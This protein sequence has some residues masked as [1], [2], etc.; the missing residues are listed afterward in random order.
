MKIRTI[1]LLSSLVAIASCDCRV[2]YSP[3]TPNP[4]YS[5]KE[6]PDHPYTVCAVDGDQKEGRKESHARFQL[7]LGDEILIT[8]V[9]PVT[10]VTF[11]MY[12]KRGGEVRNKETVAMVACCNGQVLSAAGDFTYSPPGDSADKTLK[13]VKIQKDIGDRPAGC[14]KDG[15]KD[16]ISINFCSAD[17]EGGWTCTDTK[18][19][20]GSGAHAEG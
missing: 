4:N 7:A 2:G 11:V 19:P 8:K 1:L 14:N 6:K 15:T 20:H 3:L 9:A 17:K 13:L 16:V 18:P 10:D 5:V 12:Q